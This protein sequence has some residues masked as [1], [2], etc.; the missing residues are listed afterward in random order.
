M[1][2]PGVCLVPIEEAGWQTSARL[3]RMR[4]LLWANVVETKLHDLE[5]TLKAN[6]NPNQPRMP[7]GNPD[8]GQWTSTS[9]DGGGGGNISASHLRFL[10]G[11]HQRPASA[12][13]STKRPPSGSAERRSGRQWENG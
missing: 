2:W 4:S 1:K 13:A 12:R 6:F 7:A 3:R 9:S 5:R 8:G 11:D 10:K